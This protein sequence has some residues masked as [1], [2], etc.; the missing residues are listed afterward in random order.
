MRGADAAANLPGM[1]A[2]QRLVHFAREHLDSLGLV[3]SGSRG[4]EDGR[5]SSDWDCYLVVADGARLEVDVETV[6]DDSIDLT[7]M[8][9]QSFRDYAA[10]L[11]GAEAV[12]LAIGRALRR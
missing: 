3:L 8:S 2:Y 9:L 1:N 12:T 4:R 6:I 11:D 5:P 7:T 10:L